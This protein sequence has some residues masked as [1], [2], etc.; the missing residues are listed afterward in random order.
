MGRNNIKRS[1]LVI[2]H[3]E[4]HNS[5]ALITLTMGN[6]HRYFYDFFS[7]PT[8]T[9][10]PPTHSWLT[11]LPPRSPSLPR[12]LPL[13]V[14][15]LSTSSHGIRQDLSLWDGLLSLHICKPPPP[16]PLSPT[17]T[18]SCHGAA[19]GRIPFRFNGGSN[20]IPGIFE[21]RLTWAASRGHREPQ[22]RPLC[23]PPPHCEW[24]PLPWHKAA[25]PRSAL[26]HSLEQKQGCLAPL[27]R[28]GL[29]YQIYIDRKINNKKKRS[30]W[31]GVGGREVPVCCCLGMA[32]SSTCQP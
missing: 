30:L 8:R 7:V 15:L 4:A 2:F 17:P 27:E 3:F 20:N 22:S 10:R 25:A 32:L 24:R 11:A 29:I 9:P 1:A 12:S 16:H 21:M 14:T 31:H 5:V 23:L 19:S 26:L 28:V 13:S 6:H 18:P